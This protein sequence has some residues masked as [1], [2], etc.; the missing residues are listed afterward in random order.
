MTALPMTPGT[1]GVGAVGATGTVGT[2]GVF[3]VGANVPPP[4]AFKYALR[5]ASASR[6]DLAA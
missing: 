1:S 4:T 5:A 6:Q 2:T 3:G